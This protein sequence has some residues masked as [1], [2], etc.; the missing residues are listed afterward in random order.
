MGKGHLFFIVHMQANI[1]LLLRLRKSIE[2]L[3]YSRILR[4]CVA[5]IYWSYKN[6]K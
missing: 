5:I 2:Y 4:I 1:D 3:E 6:K